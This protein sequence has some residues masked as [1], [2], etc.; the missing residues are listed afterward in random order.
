MDGLSAI[1]EIRSIEAAR[2][3]PRCPIIVLTANAFS[4]DAAASFAADA[5]DFLT[6]PVVRAVLH[7]RVSALLHKNAAQGPLTPARRLA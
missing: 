7:A 2:G 1:R 3:L 4:E 6:K 5:D